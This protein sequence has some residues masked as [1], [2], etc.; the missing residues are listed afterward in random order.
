MVLPE[1]VLPPQKRRPHRKSARSLPAWKRLL[2]LFV[3]W[4][5]LLLGVIGLVL[6]VLQGWL[7]IFTG[8]AVL[9]LVSEMA[10]EAL[11]WAFQ[12][13]PRGWRRV[14]KLRRRMQGW[15]HR[16]EDE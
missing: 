12:R 11:R 10:Y 16:G 6:P 5:L 1:K 14:S 13:W 2:L 4:T 3:G 15:L 9:S 7:M 8:A